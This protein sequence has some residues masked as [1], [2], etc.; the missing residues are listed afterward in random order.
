M[1]DQGRMES[2]MTRV[3]D[4]NYSDSCIGKKKL[5][6]RFSHNAEDYPSLFIDDPS[7]MIY[8]ES[9]AFQKLAD[10]AL[11]GGLDPENSVDPDIEVHSENSVDSDIEV[12][13][14]NSVDPDIEIDSDSSVDSD[15]EL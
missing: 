5:R 15:I 9:K 11:T 4:M 8:T 14:E 1:K 6:S 10:K 12:H 7:L 13:S 3:H 2:T